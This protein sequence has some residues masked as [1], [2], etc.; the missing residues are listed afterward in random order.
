MHAVSFADR[1]M[2]GQLKAQL[3][4]RCLLEEEEQQRRATL[5]KI[6]A[7]YS[8]ILHSSDSSLSQRRSTTLHPLTDSHAHINFPSSLAQR[9]SPAT[10]SG[11]RICAPDASPYCLTASVSEDMAASC[12]LQSESLEG[13]FHKRLAGRVDTKTWEALPCCIGRDG[14]HV[15]AAA[16]LH[17]WDDLRSHSSTWA[18]AIIVKYM[19]PAHETRMS[20]GPSSSSA[21][22]TRALT[23]SRFVTSV[24]RMI[25]LPS[26]TT[27]RRLT[28]SRASIRRAASA[29]WQ[30]SLAR[31]AA[32]AAPMPEE[33]PVTTATLPLSGPRAIGCAEPPRARR[34]VGGRVSQP[35]ANQSTHFSH[36]RG[37]VL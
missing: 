6:R 17:A 5:Y 31:D 35:R 18:L 7:P 1:W 19:T 11:F 21:A 32:T 23:C 3:Q 37:S 2:G 14:H 13:E 22:S 28:D 27:R 24:W 25:I 15:T 10:S 9:G 4:G 33:A 16:L 36:S 26:R 29:I 30:P 12:G 34:P 20:T 8:D